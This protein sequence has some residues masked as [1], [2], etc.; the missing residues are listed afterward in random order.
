MSYVF[1]AQHLEAH[2]ASLLENKLASQ[3]MNKGLTLYW[4]AVTVPSLDRPVFFDTWEEVKMQL[5]YGISAHLSKQPESTYYKLD[6][7]PKTWSK[8]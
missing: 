6:I 5:F 2:L 7:C 8:R 4:T 3:I 1:I